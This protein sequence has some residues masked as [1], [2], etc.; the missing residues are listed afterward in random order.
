MARWTPEQIKEKLAFWINAENV[1]VETKTVFGEEVKFVKEALDLSE[2]GNNAYNL[3]ET[4]VT[5]PI[6]KENSL[7]GNPTISFADFSL[8]KIGESGSGFS[9]NDYVIPDYLMLNHSE[10]VDLSGTGGSIFIVFKPNLKREIAFRFIRSLESANY[11]QSEIRRLILNGFEKFQF[12]SDDKLIQ[13]IQAFEGSGTVRGTDI[14][15][16]DLTTLC[17]TLYNAPGFQVKLRVDDLYYNSEA[18]N[19]EAL[20]EERAKFG[21]PNLVTSSDSDTLGSDLLDYL[22]ERPSAGK[23]KVETASLFGSEEEIVPSVESS[24]D[25][26]VNKFISSLELSST[27]P[28]VFE[29]L[30]IKADPSFNESFDDKNRRHRVIEL[31]RSSDSDF[32][33]PLN[34]NFSILSL[35]TNTDTGSVDD[36]LEYNRWTSSNT[37][38]GFFKNGEHFGG[39]G[40]LIT[41][42][43]TSKYSNW[44]HAIGAPLDNTTGKIQGGYDN[45]NWEVSTDELNNPQTAN[46]KKV[47]EAYNIASRYGASSPDNSSDFFSGEI[48]EIVVFKEELSQEDREKVEGYLAFK[49]NIGLVSGHTYEN[50]APS[51]DETLEIWSP[52]EEDSLAMWVDSTTVKK[53]TSSLSRKI[54]ANYNSRDYYIA[55]EDS[56]SFFKDMEDTNEYVKEFV[57]KS[58]NGAN[59]ISLQSPSLGSKSWPIYAASQT[60]ESIVLQMVEQNNGGESQV[61]GSPI[62]KFE[63][64]PASISEYDKAS[65]TPSFISRGEYSNIVKTNTSSTIRSGGIYMKATPVDSQY[66]YP[67]VVSADW[68]ESSA[69]F[70]RNKESV[71]TMLKYSADLYDV[72]KFEAFITVESGLGDNYFQEGDLILVTGSDQSHFGK[73]YDNDGIYEVISYNNSNG[74]IKVDLHPQY[75]FSKRIPFSSKR[76]GL[77]PNPTALGTVTKVTLSYANKTGIPYYV[78][79][80]DEFNKFKTNGGSIFFVM[81]PYQTTESKYLMTNGRYDNGASPIWITAG[82]PTTVVAE[83]GIAAQLRFFF[84]NET[85][86]NTSGLVTFAAR[87]A[88]QDYFITYQITFDNTAADGSDTSFDTTADGRLPTTAHTATIYT[89]APRTQAEIIESIRVL[90]TSGTFQENGWTT[91]KVVSQSDNNDN[92][93]TQLNVN[94]PE[95]SAY[96][97]YAYEGLDAFYN[98]VPGFGTEITDPLTPILASTGGTASLAINGK[99]SVDT[100]AGYNYGIY[101]FVFPG[102]T[103]DVSGV[104]EDEAQARWGIW[105]NGG[106]TTKH[107]PDSSTWGTVDGQQDNKIYICP[108]V[109]SDDFFT[110]GIAEILIFSEDLSAESRQKVEGYLSDKYGIT[111]DVEHPY[112]LN[113]PTTDQDL[114]WSPENDPEKL[115]AWYSP[116]GLEDFNNSGNVRWLDKHFSYKANADDQR[117]LNP[118]RD[119]TTYQ[120]TPVS[121]ENSASVIPTSDILSADINGKNALRIR[122]Q[123]GLAFYGFLRTMELSGFSAFMVLK[124]NESEYLSSNDYHDSEEGS[125]LELSNYFHN[126]SN[127]AA[128]TS[129]HLSISDSID[130][131]AVGGYDNNLETVFLD[132]SSVQKQ[133]RSATLSESEATNS[134]SY[135][136]L[137]LISRD[138]NGDN[139]RDYGIFLNG[140]SKGQTESASFDTDSIIISGGSH[141]ITVAE[142]IFYNSELSDFERQRIEGYLACKFDL[143]SEL[144]STH[145]YKTFCPTIERSLIKTARSLKSF[146]NSWNPKLEQNLIGLYEPSGIEF[147]EDHSE[148]SFSFKIAPAVLNDSENK[149]AIVAVKFDGDDAFYIHASDE[150]LTYESLISSNTT[151]EAKSTAAIT[152]SIGYV[153]NAFSAISALLNQ[154]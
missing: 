132:G 104:S 136:I 128:K 53:G 80:S 3:D 44:V 67:S 71:S 139:T 19:I 133:N 62:V 47:K 76:E 45:L 137:S 106:K 66:N 123:K 118:L 54:N 22:T 57:D 15:A 68:L 55:K 116:E 152:A 10:G 30:G 13:A 149:N 130:G 5:R 138:P 111:L 37:V 122:P 144:D 39:N 114:N 28:S 105:K 29:D 26:A 102:L 78:A 16:N 9:S 21:L 63:Q 60:N 27:I 8:S 119:F 50:A 110:G 142:I 35:V 46:S 95:D 129:Y 101:D 113:A 24:N 148:N 99:G 124:Y 75:S 65:G 100:V 92:A 112:T 143:Q 51:Y 4:N 82:G 107:Y 52:L 48:A 89:G 85:D 79:T 40:S 41:V 38:S 1:V 86:V 109:S 103:E 61:V 20:N 43:K 146:S 150:N 125:I 141:D 25:S 11:S 49:Y 97:V 120:P 91:E 93:N 12:P 14:Y 131:Y 121:T 90:F 59:L 94:G 135:Q 127:S 64:V 84:E 17:P 134:N 140:V 69:L 56:D 32:Y 77:Y 7:N 145:P 34:G 18:S 153:G 74:E 154:D 83:D 108:P 72:S 151:T 87:P 2:N 88:G 115:F 126:D 98:T 6:L 70:I 81:K 147:S 23:Y 96:R 117:H 42:P 36:T 58:L 33:E 73:T 31:F